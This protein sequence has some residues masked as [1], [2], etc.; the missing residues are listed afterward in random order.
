MS[1]SEAKSTEP[2]NTA[3]T[4]K[5]VT[6]ASAA[7]DPPGAQRNDVSAPTQVRVTKLAEMRSHHT[8]CYAAP[9]S[10][11]EVRSERIASA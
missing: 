8:H 9:V 3:L 4:P 5:N 11:K 1:N 6:M 7:I 2:L 10:E